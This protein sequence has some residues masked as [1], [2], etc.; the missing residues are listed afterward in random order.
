MPAA[1]TDFAPLEFESRVARLREA[2]KSRSVD[3]MLI[4]DCEALNYFTGYDTS[5]NLYRACLVPRD[6]TPIMVLRALDVAPFREQAWFDACIGFADA[7]DPVAKV[8][9]AIRARGFAAASVGFDS[10]SH[11]LSVAISRSTRRRSF[12]KWP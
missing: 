6:G 8:G 10:G 1:E 12:T 11:A 3:V 4:D 5:L 9:E 7:D 2:M